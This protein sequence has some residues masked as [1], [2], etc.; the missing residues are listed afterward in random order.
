[1]HGKLQDHLVRSEPLG[2]DANF[3]IYY[4]F[5]GDTKNVYC[6]VRDEDNSDN[7]GK[8]KIF[9]SDQIYNLYAS[10]DGRGKREKRLRTQ[11]ERRFLEIIDDGRRTAEI[12]DVWQLSPTQLK[13]GWKTSGNEFIGRKVRRIYDDVTEADGRIMAYLPAN[14]KEDDP[15]FWFMVH[16]DPKGDGEDLERYE[17]DDAL[18]NVIENKHVPRIDLHHS[19]ISEGHE[20]IGRKIAMIAEDEKIVYATVIKYR[21]KKDENAM[22]VEKDGESGSNSS[23]TKTPSKA[24][25]KGKE[26]LSPRQR[27]QSISSSDHIEWLVKFELPRGKKRTKKTTNQ[28]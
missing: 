4:L 12:F 17:L 25:E 10:L 6:L 27:S 22:D 7:C 28:K 1:M 13:E 26:P 14:P 2:F 8:W 15:E 20:W 5:A 3:N 23:P 18:K 11:L 9:P 16:D 24:M 19:W 21:E